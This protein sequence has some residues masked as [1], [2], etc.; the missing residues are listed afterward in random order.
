MVRGIFNYSIFNSILNYREKIKRK[1]Y[2]FLK[3]WK[4]IVIF[5]YS[6]GFYSNNIILSKRNSGKINNNV[7]WLI[8]FIYKK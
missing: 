3:I 5:K 8:V 7:I 2:K 4:I 1:L 6:S